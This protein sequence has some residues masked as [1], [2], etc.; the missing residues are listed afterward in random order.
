MC[1]VDYCIDGKSPYISMF[2]WRIRFAVAYISVSF[3]SAYAADLSTEFEKSTL[4]SE[5][6]KLA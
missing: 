4:R 5:F 6:I 1:T 3:A 2:F